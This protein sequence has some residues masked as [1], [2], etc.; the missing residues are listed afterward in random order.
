MCVWCQHSNNTQT[1][2]R[3]DFNWN[4]TSCALDAQ[5]ADKSIAN[6]AGNIFSVDRV[7]C[8]MHQILAYIQP[9]HRR[10]A[11]ARAHTHDHNTATNFPFDLRNFSL[12]KL[13]EPSIRC[14]QCLQRKWPK[15][16]KRYCWNSCI[17]VYKVCLR[18]S[19]EGRR[20]SWCWTL[21]A[22]TSLRCAHFHSV[23][24][25]LANVIG[26]RCRWRRCWQQTHWPAVGA[27]RVYFVYLFHRIC[28]HLP[29]R[30]LLLNLNGTRFWVFGCC[31]EPITSH[32]FCATNAFAPSMLSASD[33]CVD[34][35]ISHQNVQK[36]VCSRQNPCEALMYKYMQIL[37]R[38]SCRIDQKPM[39][40]IGVLNKQLTGSFIFA[41]LIHTY[42]HRLKLQRLFF[43]LLFPQITEYCIYLKK[44]IQMSVCNMWDWSN[45]DTVC[46]SARPLL[47]AVPRRILW[48]M[49]I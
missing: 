7:G 45:F 31:I 8:T 30:L 44:K 13:L 15:Q 4:R 35:K 5:V 42:W 41:S 9:T 10:Q 12:K 47:N 2:C 3:Y 24:N 23:E 48:K 16:H 22:S 29:N 46:V 1:Y 37:A 33:I 40:R 20:S 21:C 36:E 27:L 39:H 43:G 38:N 6:I 32:R 11:S 28:L 26:H 17:F 18:P 49:R 34:R 25:G 14:A 19:L